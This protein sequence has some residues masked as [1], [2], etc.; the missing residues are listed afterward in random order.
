MKLNCRIQPV[1]QQVNSSVVCSV[2]L[3]ASALV[4]NGCDSST[5]VQ[6]PDVGG[7]GGVDNNGSNNTGQPVRTTLAADNADDLI[8]DSLFGFYTT[9]AGNDSVREGDFP[10]VLTSQVD[11]DVA[12]SESVADS[13]RFSDTNVQE[14][15]VDESDRIKIDGDVLFALEMPDTNYPGIFPP[16]AISD[17]S[18][19]DRQPVETLSAYRL[20][21]NSSGLLSRL[22]L[23]ALNGTPQ[24]MYLHKNAASSQLVLLSNPAFN[25]WQNWRSTSVWAGLQTQVSWID[26]SNP[27]ELAIKSTMDI[28]GQLISSRKINNQLILVTRYHPRI[29]GLIDYPAT[30]DDA[31]HNR[32]LIANADASSLLPQYRLTQNNATSAQAVIS[33]N[34][35]Y[36]S[37]VANPNDESDRRLQPYPNPSVISIITIDLNSQNTRLNSTCFMGES[38]TVY[39]SQE[40]LYLATTE[41]N[42]NFSTDD[43]NRLTVDYIEPEI[44]T[45]VH[46]FGFTPGGTAEFKGSGSVNG[47]L[48]WYADRKPFRMSEKDGNLRIVSFNENQSGSPVTLS[49]LAESGGE[50]LETLSTLPNSSRPDHIGKPGERLYASRFVGD[51]AYLVTFRVIDPLY[52]LDLSNPYDPAIAGELELPGYSEYLHPVNES[53]LIGLGKDAVADNGSAWGDG[54]GAWYQG[55]KLALFD[56]SDPAQPFVADSKVIGKRGTETPALF[57]HHSFAWLSGTANRNARLAVPLQLHNESRRSSNPWDFSD[58]TSNGLLTMEVDPASTSFVEVPDWTFESRTAGHQYSPVS[59]SSD[60]AVIGAD[61]GL[62]VIH[63]GALQYG[64]WGEAAPQ[65]STE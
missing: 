57:Q 44:T 36:R 64:E 35:C 56:V 41:Y 15:G 3:L 9:I 38:E 24:G 21:K 14:A 42:Y 54:R 23:D 22:R 61:G 65:S 50:R 8:R 1:K 25:S 20:A 11:A 60:R 13:G 39:V 34:R 16:F 51:R 62:Y 37:S 40:S 33:D 28:D 59:I 29:N 17:L 4:L 32:D 47:H 43:F 6:T 49:V 46:K 27:Q 26:V 12:V 58:W 19:P 31:E 63:N 30:N 55:L 5:L 45:D 10:L 52:V 18:V 7:T 48:G 2:V 53:L